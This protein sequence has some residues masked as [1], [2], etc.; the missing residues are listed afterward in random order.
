MVCRHIFGDVANLAS[1]TSADTAI[2][3]DDMETRVSS[4]G[5]EG[6]VVWCS[7]YDVRWR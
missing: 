1:R 6:G 4:L 5:D 2:I 7:V 3:D